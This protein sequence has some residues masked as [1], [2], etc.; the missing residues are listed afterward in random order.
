MFNEDRSH[1]PA[2][3]QTIEAAAGR[4]HVFVKGLNIAFIIGCFGLLLAT[5]LPLLHPYWPLAAIAEHFALQI[6]IA[7]TVLGALALVLRRWRWVTIIIGIAFIQIWIIHPYWHSKIE[8]HTANVV[9]HHSLKVISLNIWYVNNDLPAAIDYLRNS[10]ADVIGLVEVWSHML[11][12]L[13]TLNDVYPYRVECVTVDRF[14]GEMLLSKHPFQT[15]G[16]GRIAG[17][18]PV[19]VWGT[20]TPPGTVSPITVA[21]THLAW[22]F[23]QS[24]LP[25]NSSIPKNLPRLVQTEQALDLIGP[26]NQL[27][28]DLILMGDFNMAPWSRAQ[29]HLR[30]TTR[31][32]NKGNLAPS[33]PSA[34]PAFMRVPIDH[35]MTRGSLHLISLQTGPDVG[36]DHRPVEAIITLATP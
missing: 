12:A 19:L 15:E 23:R 28:D 18:L 31:L 30:Q 24:S 1:L 8:T 20:L 14:C 35:V 29:G 21:V 27:D 2:S 9:D 34:L 36:S 6:L 16:K 3:D 33:W 10:D 26:L 25:D 5:F 17:K 13:A 11:P 7:A 22:P 32:D 4:R